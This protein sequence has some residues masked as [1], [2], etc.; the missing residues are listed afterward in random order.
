[1]Q[2]P[3]RFVTAVATVALLALTSGP[4]T[5]AQTSPIDV[6]SLL[7]QWDPV[8]DSITQY[9][10][11]VTKLAANTSVWLAHHLPAMMSQA[12]AGAGIGVSD[13][14][15]GISIGLIPVR[16]GLMNQFASTVSKP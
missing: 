6:D 5:H 16:V 2:G 7:G 13:N 11:D 14:A 10:T 3:E 1:M 15:G 9:A 4:P 12:G 8:D